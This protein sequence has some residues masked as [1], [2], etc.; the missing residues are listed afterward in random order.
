MTYANPYAAAGLGFIDEVLVP[1]LT[2]TRLVD[3]LSLL[4]NK[5]LLHHTVAIEA[6]NHTGRDLT[7]EI[8]E[9]VPVPAKDEDDVEVEE[10]RVEPLWQTWEPEET[11]LE[12]GRRWLVDLSAGQKKELVAEY[13]VSIPAKSELVGGNRRGG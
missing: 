7:L 1:R 6:V 10:T 12:G 9:R 11:P 5:R 4:R 3:G 2:R 13:A 8:R